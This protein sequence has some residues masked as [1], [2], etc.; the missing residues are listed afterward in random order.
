[1]DRKSGGGEALKVETFRDSNDSSVPTAFCRARENSETGA[2]ENKR[3]ETFRKFRYFEQ[4]DFP[5]S[6]DNNLGGRNKNFV[7]YEEKSKRVNG[8]EMD[9]ERERLGI[10]NN[11]NDLPFP[12]DVIHSSPLSS[13]SS[14][15]RFFLREPRL[16]V[17]E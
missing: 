11:E 13:L 7:T 10:L 1:M 14:S 6:M 17:L 15:L 4:F 2:Q 12:L 8:R 5:L 3:N 9:R 16:Q